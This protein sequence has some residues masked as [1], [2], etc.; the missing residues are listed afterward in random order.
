MSLAEESRIL[1]LLYTVGLMCVGVHVSVADFSGQFLIDLKFT[2]ER[3]INLFFENRVLS[4]DFIQ[5]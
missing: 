5:I 1:F 3:E 4:R 2:D